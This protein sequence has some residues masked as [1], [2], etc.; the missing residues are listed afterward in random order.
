MPEEAKKVDDA[1]ALCPV[2]GRRCLLG[3]FLKHLDACKQQFEKEELLKPVSERQMAPCWPDLPLPT[4]P[5][6]ALDAW[7]AA[8]KKERNVLSCPGCGRGFEKLQALKG[9]VKRCCP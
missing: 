5:G 1:A 3:S 7:N 4:K 9:H 8:V 2:C 6:K